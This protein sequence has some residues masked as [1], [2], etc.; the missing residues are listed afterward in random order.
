M[1]GA[2]LVQAVVL[3]TLI[4]G[5]LG[6]CRKPSS[7]SSG[8]ASA[9]SASPIDSLAPGELIPGDKKAFAI[10]L[11]KDVK[12]DQAFPDVIFA[13]G[14]VS[15]S[16]LANYVRARVRDG[17]ASIGA[18]A[19]VFDQVK[20]EGEATRLLAIRIYSGPGGR[21]ARIV[22]RD[23]TPPPIPN[24]PSEEERWKQFGMGTDGKFLDPKHLH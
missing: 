18:T 7:E 11:P 19:T 20:A 10:V 21:G 15:A 16:D 4:A 24:L 6:A 22:V 2:R 12:I 13:S 3:A 5:V 8:D 1:N 17:S 14:P 23:I 9:P